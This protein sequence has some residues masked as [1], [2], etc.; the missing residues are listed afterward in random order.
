MNLD[1]LRRRR[2]KRLGVKV[3]N[4]AGQRRIFFILERGTKKFP[5]DLGLWM[6]YL[7]FAK[8]QKANKKV[9]G[10]LTRVVRLHP[11]KAE[12]WVL[13]AG[14]AVEGGDVQ[15]ARGLLQRGVRFCG[16]Q[17]GIWVEWGRVE[18]GWI[19]KIARR[20]E[21]LGN[22]GRQG[23]GRQEGVEE[24]I[25]GDV[26]ALPKITAEDMRPDDGIGAGVDEEALE[27]LEKSPALEGA[28]SMA[29]FDE[30][31]KQFKNDEK[32]G[33][34][35]FDMVAR[36]DELPCTAKI[37]DHILGV[38]QQAAPESPEMFIRHIRQP[39]IGLVPT[40]AGFPTKLGLCLERM[41]KALKSLVPIST[42]PGTARSRATLDGYIIVWLLQYLEV[43]DLDSD[44]QR[45][46][47]TTLKKVWSQYQADSALVPGGRAEDRATLIRKLQDRG[48]S[49][50]AKSARVWAIQNWPNESHLFIRDDQ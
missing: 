6:Q 3:L 5:G 40:A 46:I 28:I 12:V 14:W 21:I 39:A 35:F 50:I 26:V 45:V 30:A 37:L 4:H 33:L 16:G 20:R 1:S 11:T 10:I 13:A 17:G 49:S 7:N 34:Q 15:E 27:K 43:D 41:R 8:K 9:Q 42:A 29:I 25:E 2:V 36:F 22:D 19:G 48:L 38:L 32:L 18:M 24:G 23:E 31:M 44:I 47:V